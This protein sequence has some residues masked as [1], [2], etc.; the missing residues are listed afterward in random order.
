MPQ[1]AAAHKNYTLSALCECF[2][3]I[4][5]IT[6]GFAIDLQEL[7]EI[8]RATPISIVSCV[9]CQIHL[10]DD[11]LSIFRLQLRTLQYLGR[12]HTGDLVERDRLYEVMCA[13]CADEHREQHAEQLRDAFLARKARQAELLRIARRSLKEYYRT[14]E[15]RAK[16]SRAK[17]RAGN[18]CQACGRSGVQLEVHHNTYERLGQELPTDLVVLCRNCHQL[19]HDHGALPDAA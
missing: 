15:W 11:N 2:V 10:P 16:A 14:P 6:E 4:P 12:F 8:R 7:V 3:P 18:R 5:A 19:Y 17:I 9:Q 1:I 13:D